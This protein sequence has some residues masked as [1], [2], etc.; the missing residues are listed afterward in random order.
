MN[1]Y[2]ILKIIHIIGAA[3]LFGTGMGTALYMYLANR[4]GNVQVIAKTTAQVVKAD[5]LFTGTAA[6]IQP[7][8]GLWLA[9][10]KHYPMG[11]YWIWGSMLGYVIAGVFWLPVVY[12]Q[13][14]LRNMATQALANN[15][16]L[17]KR[18][19]VLFRYWFYCGWPAFLSL[20]AVLFL[21]A[22]GPELGQY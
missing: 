5:W 19:T 20:V 17:P 12:W 1:L 14:Q 4:S 22:N 7:I 13:I 10:I 15:Q 9:Y 3:V 21:M 16:P 8:T 6:I 2:V 11:A 18:Y